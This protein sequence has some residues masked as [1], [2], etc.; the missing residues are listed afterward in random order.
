VDVQVANPY[1]KA[2]TDSIFKANQGVFREPLS[3]P[4][5]SLRLTACLVSQGNIITVWQDTMT[6]EF[7]RG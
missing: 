7:A 2:P 3:Q 1:Q 6:M 4:V 5:L